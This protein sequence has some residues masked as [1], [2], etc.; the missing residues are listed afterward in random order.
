MVI[1]NT[2]AKQAV[3]AIAGLSPYQPGKPIDELQRELGLDNIVKLASNENPLGPSELVKKAIQNSISGVSQYPDGSGYY[4]KEALSKKLGVTTD[5]LTLGNGSNDVLD[6]IARVFL[7][8]GR[9]A[10]FSEYAFVVYAI[11]TQSVGA[12]ACVAKANAY[13]HDLNAMMDL[14]GDKTAVVFIANPNNPTGTWLNADDLEAFI[15]QLPQHVV[16]VLDEAYGEYL[17]Q[18]TIVNTVDWLKSYPNLII[19]RTFSKAYGL[20]GLRVGYA[21][22]SPDIADLL[23]RVRQPFNVNALALEAAETALQDEAYIC[24]SRELNGKGLKQLGEGFDKLGLHYIP[25][26][27]NFIS[28]EVGESAADVYEKLL[29]HGV[30]VRPVAAYNMPTYLRVSVG[31]PE[32]NDVFLSALEKVLQRV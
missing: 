19:T 26:V 22:S 2:F 20:A 24:K 4:L 11:S 6:S 32:E 12:T 10:V 30:I 1:E 5:M 3:D 9:E 21:I 14:V 8:V 18:E 25:S 27:G 15:R 13:G 7:S 16:V 29:Q 31:L 17:D 23:N 28:I